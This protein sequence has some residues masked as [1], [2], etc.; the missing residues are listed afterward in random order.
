MLTGT[1]KGVD[2]RGV[3]SGLRAG[4]LLRQAIGSR[5]QYSTNYILQ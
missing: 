2:P 3:Q 1:L 4:R 5:G